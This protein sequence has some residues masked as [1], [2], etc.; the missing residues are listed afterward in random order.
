MY[1]RT[2]RYRLS[3]FVA[4]AH[5]LPSAVTLAQ[6]KYRARWNVFGANN[7]AQA[8]LRTPFVSNAKPGILAIG[9]IASAP[10]IRYLKRSQPA[11]IS[12]NKYRCLLPIVNVSSTPRNQE[13]RS[14]LFLSVVMAPSHGHAHRG[15]RLPGLDVS[16]YQRSARR[17]LILRCP[18]PHERGTPYRR[19]RRPRSPG[20]R[21]SGSRSRLAGCPGPRS[22]RPV[23]TA[24]WS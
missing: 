10:A 5:D 14:F 16:A 18:N 20:E 12:R 13:L 6:R 1:H 17:R 15:L 4:A 3:P 8:T 21:C 2:R 22:T 7:L 23:A 11:E 9:P 24:S 19:D